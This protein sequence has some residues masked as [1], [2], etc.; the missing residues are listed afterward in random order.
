LLR[1]R[2][3]RPYWHRL[4]FALPILGRLQQQ[5]AA[6]HLSQTLTLSLSAGVPLIAALRLAIQASQHPQWMAHQASIEAALAAGHPL[7]E[8]LAQHAQLPE[9][10]LEMIQTGEQS[11]TLITLLGRAASLYDEQLELHIKAMT[12]WLE[13]MMMGVLAVLVG[14][15]LLALYLPIFSMGSLL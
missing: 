12:T 7:H 5:A 13:P 9:L 14:G 1:Q 3:F 10:L 2:R 4:S 6:A 11:G 8:A 15:L